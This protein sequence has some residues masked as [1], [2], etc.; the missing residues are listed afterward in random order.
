MNDLSRRTILAAALVAMGAIPA[1]GQSTG[2]PELSWYGYMKLDASWDEAIINTGNFARWV[3][4]PEMG[5]SHA[6]FNMTARQTRLG[7]R[8]SS[9][10][11]GAQLTGRW[12]ADF[13]AGAAENKNGLQVRHA[14]VDMVW[15][16]GWEVLAGQTSDV[17]SPLNPTTLNY[18]VAWWAGNIGYRRPQ[19]RVTRKVAR[20]S[21]LSSR[22]YASVGRR[23]S[24]RRVAVKPSGRL[25]RCS[26]M[27]TNH[28]RSSARI[29]RKAAWGK[30]GT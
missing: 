8:A 20:Q 26:G 5:H 10:A 9:E 1:L 25:Q 23:T 18:T 28:R 24:P 4:A 12:E 16:S 22:V 15:P 21:H 17:I 30:V 14:Y 2:S 13:Y 29:A 3:A 7:F 11:A 19:L 27:P 6:D